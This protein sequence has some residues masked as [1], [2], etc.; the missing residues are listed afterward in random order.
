M[1]MKD[2]D[3]AVQNLLNSVPE[4][5]RQAAAA[6]LAQY[7][8]RFFDMAKADAWA[9][10]RRLMAGDVDVVSELDSA[11][12]NDDF[13]VKVKANTARWENIANYNKVRDDLRNE[14]L[15]RLVPIVGSLL[16]SLVGL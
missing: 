5:Q 13:I 6:L 10:L 7:G 9:Y 14:I 1:D 15:L 4:D 2:F 8:P 16:A 12:S 11:M 3:I